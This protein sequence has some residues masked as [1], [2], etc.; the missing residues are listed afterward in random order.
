VAHLGVQAAEAL[1]HAHAEG[2]IHRDVK[3]ANL[4][5][6]AKGKLWV[7]DFGLAQFQSQASLTLTGDLVGTVRYMSPEQA[8]GKRSVVDQ[9][10]DVYSLGVT[11]YELLTLEP[12]FAGGDRQELLRQIALEEPRSPRRITK[13]VPAE[14]ETIVLKAMAKAPEERYA[15][16]QELADDLKRFLEDKPIRARRPS[17]RQRA[18][19]WA[20]RHKTVV[21]A[22]IVV[23]VLAVVALA[24]IAALIWRSLERERQAL[25]RERQDSYFQRITLAEREWEANNLSR[26]EQL[27]KDCPEDLRGWEW[28]YLKRLRHKS[29][30]P[31]RHDGAVHSVA[32]S[33]NGDCFASS[34][35]EGFVKVWDA[36]TGQQLAFFRAHPDHAHSVAFSLDGARLA[37]GGWDRTVKVWDLNAIRR[38]QETSPL[39]RLKHNFWVVSVVFSPDG[40]RLAVATGKA[41]ELGE[42]KIWDTATGQELFS[43]WGHGARANCVVFSPEG[44][45]L[46]TASADRTVRVWDARTGQENLTLRGHGQ[47]VHCVAFSP[48]SRRL[49]SA[50]YDRVVR[51][52]DVTTG[53][54]I[55]E[56]RDHNWVIHCVAFSPDNRHVATAGE[57]STVRVW[58]VTTG[59]ETIAPPLKHTGRA[60]GVVFSPD[61]RRLV[62]GSLD[63]TAKVWDVATG[64]LLHLLR[65]PTGGVQSVAFSSDGKRLV[66]GGTDSAVKVWDEATGEIHTLRGHAS[67]VQGVAFSP[68]GKRIA[69]ASADGTVKLWEAPPVSEEAGNP[70]K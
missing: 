35:Q 55:R 11:L 56:L 69:S 2:V 26:M 6:D 53:Q 46:A 22:A 37:T 64:K 32:F 65:D 19:K 59:Q 50:G 63:R 33:P 23:L 24:V 54:Q 39:Q 17:L 28:Y 47:M 18:V 67:W 16:A 8:L 20:R 14:L 1:E 60:V 27:L 45:R 57:D 48:D 9:R 7:T 70:G 43:L 31:L 21:R 29:L 30:P 52:W 62:S 40:Q 25:E 5:V 13:A 36:Q 10:T 15:T 4:L 51:V 12:A 34:D 42:V 44:G 58:D 49:A 66:W 3:P 61:C 68:D 41:D 38:G